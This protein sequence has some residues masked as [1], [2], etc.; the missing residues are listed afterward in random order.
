MSL[1]TDELVWAIRTAVLCCRNASA[2]RAENVLS[3]YR[4]CRMA[5]RAVLRVFVCVARP[6]RSG[7]PARIPG[8]ITDITLTAITHIRT[9][10]V[11]GCIT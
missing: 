8:I 7:Q 6:G 5:I 10:S 2:N 9:T 4:L 1:I 3:S 11:K